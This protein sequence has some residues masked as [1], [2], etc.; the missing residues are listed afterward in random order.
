MRARAASAASA[1]AASALARD[2]ASMALASSTRRVCLRAAAPACVCLPLSDQGA[3]RRTRPAA[4]ATD[5]GRRSKPLSP[6]VPHLVV[7]RARL[8]RV[9]RRRAHGCSERRRLLCMWADARAAPWRSLC[10]RRSARATEQEREGVVCRTRSAFVAAEVCGVVRCCGGVDGAGCDLCCVCGTG[11]LRSD[12]V[13]GRVARTGLQPASR[14]D[15]T[16]ETRSR[17]TPARTFFANHT[18]VRPC[19]RALASTITP[20]STARVR[21]PQRLPMSCRF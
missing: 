17:L 14:S 18:S 21:V 11:G 6:A 5:D 9:G 10:A 12:G 2:Q 13:L 20:V 19:T 3:C 8:A 4:A 15:E 7:K 16:R 1:S